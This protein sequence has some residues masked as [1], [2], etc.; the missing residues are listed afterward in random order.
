[1]K[2]E[3]TV[4]CRI[5]VEIRP[6]PFREPLKVPLPL[7]TYSAHFKYIGRFRVANL[8]GIS[9]NSPQ[10]A[11]DNLKEVLETRLKSPEVSKEMAEDI[12]FA[13]TFFWPSKEQKEDIVVKRH[14]GGL[15]YVGLKSSE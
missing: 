10:E 5:E 8:R 7:M 15:I 9:P 6:N 11:I 14:D 3:D 13:L 2:E 4:R 1:M 12:K